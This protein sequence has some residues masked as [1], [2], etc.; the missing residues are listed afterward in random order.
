MLEEDSPA[1]M[2]LMFKIWTVI[3]AGDDIAEIN[4]LLIYMYKEKKI[5]EKQA[6]NCKIRS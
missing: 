3:K 2:P 5:H 1:L 4:G 6:K